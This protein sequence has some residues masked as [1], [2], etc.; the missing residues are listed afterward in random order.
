MSH[1]SGTVAEVV[2]PLKSRQSP[3]LCF[4][5]LLE[6]PPGG[7]VVLDARR[8]ALARRSRLHPKGARP[9]PEQRGSQQDEG[10]KL[11]SPTSVTMTHCP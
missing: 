4:S 3:D 7:K 8:C 2:L 11:P 6:L 1:L 9:S 10:Q 5:V